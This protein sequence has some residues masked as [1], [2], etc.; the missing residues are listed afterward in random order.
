[1]GGITRTGEVEATLYKTG[2]SS[3]AITVP[4]SWARARGLRAGD[5]V[6]L[7]LGKNLTLVPGIESPLL[8]GANP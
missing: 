8:R 3:I 1:M 5:K 6:R 7:R 4:L 2:A